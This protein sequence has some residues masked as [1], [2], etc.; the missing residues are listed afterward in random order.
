MSGG[1][2]GVG[3]G[4]ARGGVKENHIWFY[5]KRLRRCEESSLKHIVLPNEH[6]ESF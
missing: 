2:G 3:G 1:E 5:E 4:G 6:S